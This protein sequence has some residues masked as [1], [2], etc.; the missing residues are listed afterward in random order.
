ME[1]LFA[2]GGFMHL[3]FFP[4][5]INETGDVVTIKD[6]INHIDHIC[7]LGGIKKIGFGSD[8]D[9]IDEYVEDLEHV[10]KYQNLINEL[11]KHYSEDDV[12]GFAYR[13]FLN[14]VMPLDK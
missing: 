2:K 13:N 8:F 4:P 6:I 12:R 1:H 10:G 5:F 3:V 14:H 7:A 11:L 9:G